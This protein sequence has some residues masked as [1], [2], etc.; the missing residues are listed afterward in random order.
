[1]EERTRGEVAIAQ[2][3]HDRGGSKGWRRGEQSRTVRG[4]CLRN[5]A[6]QRWHRRVEQRTGVGFAHRGIGI[7]GFTHCRVEE[8]GQRRCRFIGGEDDSDRLSEEE[9]FGVSSSSGDDDNSSFGNDFEAGEKG[10][11]VHRNGICADPMTCE[12]DASGF[13]FAEDFLDKVFN[14]EE[15]AY[16]AYKQLARLRVSVWKVRRINDSHNHPLIA[17]MFSHLLPSHRNL[18][19]SDKAQ[20][21]SLKKFGIATPKI[22]AYMAGQSHEEDVSVAKGYEKIR[23]PKGISGTLGNSSSREPSGNPEQPT[24]SELSIVSEIP[25]QY[26]PTGCRGRIWPGSCLRFRLI[27]TE[28]TRTKRNPLVVTPVEP[29]GA[30]DDNFFLGGQHI[31]Q[32]FAAP[33]CSTHHGGLPTQPAATATSP[34]RAAAFTLTQFNIP[35]SDAFQLWDAIGKSS[36]ANRYKGGQENIGGGWCYW[37]RLAELDGG[38]RERDCWRGCG[39]GADGAAGKEK[40]RERVEAESRE[41]ERD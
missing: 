30:G 13:R 34:E 39:G 5:Y 28:S 10:D 15:E 7:R 37:G 31:Q 19:E 25:K 9:Y 27:H 3:V 17:T 33:S 32:F 20:V 38:E 23:S 1:M 16:A 6:T 14:T 18:S 4:G 40:V 21:D 24:S 36:S 12:G 2:I 8:N 29:R 11:D 41:R 22:M 35:S 26:T